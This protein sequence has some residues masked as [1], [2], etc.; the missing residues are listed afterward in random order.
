MFA[1]RF[2]F[3]CV[4]ILVAVCLAGCGGSSSKPVSVTLSQ[5]TAT[6]DPT[7]TLTLTATVANDKNNDGVTWTQ[8]GGGTLT[9]TTSSATYT[10]PAATSSVQTVTITATSVADTS[11]SASATLTIPAKLTITTTGGASG[12]MAGQVGTAYSVQLETTA[13]IPPYTWTLASGN[14]LPAC[15]SMTSSGLITSNGPLTANCAV[16]PNL[17]FDVTDSGNPPMTASQSLDL[18]IAAAPAIVFST[19]TVPPATGTYNSTYTGS[20]LASGG[21]GGLTY[22]LASGSGPLPTGL[23]LG[24]NGA[25][26]GTLTA[27]G[28][29]PFIIQ[30]ADAFGDVQP[31]AYTITVNPETPTLS[32]AAIETQTYGNAPFQVTATDAA[33]TPSTGAITYSL[34]PGQSSV[35]TV[36]SSGMVTLTGAGTVYL[37]ASQAASGNYAAATAT[38]SFTVNGEVPTLTFATISA[39]TYG[40][41]PFTISASD[42]SSTQS[43]GAITYALT[44]GHISAGTVSS[45]G[46]VTITGVGTIYLTASQAANGNFVATS[47]N[48]TITVAPEAATVTLGSLAQTYTGSPLAATATTTPSGIAVSFNYIGTNGTTYGPSATAPT[49][50]GSYSVA[51]TISDPDYTGSA[52]GT[53][54]IAPATATVTIGTQ[55][56]TYTGSPI[57]ATATTTPTGISV[58]FTYTGTGT[59]TYGPSAT[60]PTNAGSYSVAGTI[61]NPNYTGTGSGTLTI[62]QATATVTLGSLSQTYIGSPLAA[63]ATTTPTGL[64]VTF[65]Y[66]GTGTTSYP[67]TSTPPTNAGTYSV[68]GTVS[69]ANYI[70]SGSGTLTIQQATATFMLGNLSQTYTGS[71]LAASVTTTPSDLAV[72]FM[73]TGTGTTNYPATSTPPT[74]AGTYSVTVVVNSAAGGLS[75]NYTGSLSE[76][77]TIAPEPVTLTFTSSTI[78]AYRTY[79]NPAFTVVASDA[80]GP[81]SSG[82]ITYSVTSGPATIGSTTGLVTLTNPGSAAETVYLQAS[83]ASSGNYAS[84][85]VTAS[86]TVYPMLTLPVTTLPTGAVGTS[87]NRNLNLLASGGNGVYSWAVAPSGVTNLAAA[88]LSMF[89]GAAASG[90]GVVSGTLPIATTGPESFSVTVSDTAGNSLTVLM[91][92]TINAALTVSTTTLP[93]GISGSGTSYSQTLAAVGGT[94]TYSSWAVTTG[95]TQLAALGLSLNTS[96]GVISNGTSTLNPGSANFTITVKD[97]SGATATSSQLTINIYAPLTLPAA[98]VTV[99]GPA[100]FG[101][102][103]GEAINV[104]G[105][106]GNY[107]WN[108]TN[109][110][111]AA[112]GLTYTTTGGSPAGSQMYIGGTAPSTA[113][114]INFTVQVT[115]NLT[116][117]STSAIQYSIVVGPTTPLTLQPASGTVL[118]G[119]ITGENYNNQSISL[120]NGTYSGYAFSVGING[121]AVTAGTSWTLPDN[122]TASSSGNTLTISGTPNGTTAITLVVKGTDS[123]QDIAGP[124]TYTLTPT[125]PA[126]LGLPAAGALTAATIGQSYSNAINVTGGDQATYTWTVNSTTLTSGT[127]FAIGATGISAESYGGS[128]LSISGPCATYGTAT[129]DVAVSDIGTGQAIS[130]PVQYTI[131][132][133]P[134]QP[135]ALSPSSNPLPSGTY[136]PSGVSSYPANVYLWASG[137]SNSGY[138]YSVTV[139]GTTTGVTVGNT[140][141][142]GDGL[143]VSTPLAGANILN[144][145]GT[146]T[147]AGD[148]PL[149][150]TLN[151]SANDPVATASY[152]ISI[153]N[154]AAGY[155]VSGNITY[156]GSHTGWTY[157]E[158]INEGGGT[159]GLGTV[160]SE[161]QL[162]AGGAYTIHGVTPGTYQVYAFMDT[163]NNGSQNAVDPSGYSGATVTVSTGNVSGANDTLID[164]TGLNLTSSPTWDTS[165]GWGAFSGGALVDFDIIKNNG[166]ELAAGYTVQWSA[167]SNFSSV[168][169]SQC[170]AATG[171]TT[172]WIVTGIS[173]SGPYYFR[174][175]GI[176]GSCATPTSTGPWSAPSPALTIAAPAGNPVSGTVTIPS[177][178]TLTG[179]PLYVGFYNT[180]TSQIYAT[181]ISNPSNSTP[182]AYS[183]NVPTGSSYFFFAT[184]DQNKTGIMN[185]PGQISNTNSLSGMTLIPITG[186]TTGLDLDLTPYAVSAQAILRMQNTQSTDLSGVTTNSY[187]LRFDV[188][189]FAKLPVSVELATESTPGVIVPT[190]IATG[191]FNGYSDEFDYWPG[192]NGDIP[193]QGDTYKLN[194]I[195]SDGSSNSTTNTPANPLIVTV[196]PI[197]NAFATNLAPATTGVSL[198]PGFTWSYPS[199]ASSSDLYSFSLSDSNGDTIWEIPA[200]HSSSSGFP[201]TITPDITWAVDPTGSGDVPSDPLLNSDST[202]WW[203]ISTSDANGDEAT[204]QVAF[205]TLGTALSLPTTNPSTLPATAILN[206][207]YYGSISVIGGVAPYYWN[208]NFTS[209]NDNLNW[210]TGPDGSSL[211]ISGT[212]NQ[213][214]T[215][216]FQAYVSDSTG[217]SSGWQTYTIT[218]NPYTT[219]D[220]PVSGSISFNG[221]GSSEPPVT[222]T[223]SGNGITQTA[224]SDSKGMYQ[225]PSVPN[226]SYTIT[227]S[228]TGPATSIFTPTSLPVTVNGSFVNN[229]NINAYVGYTVTGMAGY[230]GAQTGPI[231]LSMSGC[232]SNPAPGTAITAPGAFTIHGVPPGVYTLQAWMDGLKKGVPNLSDPVGNTYNVLVPNANNANVSVSLTDQGTPVLSKASFLF[233]A[234]G[235]ANG[236]VLNI[237]PDYEQNSLGN[238]AE[239]ATSYSVQWSTTQ[240]FTSIAGSTSFPAAGGD[241]GYWVLNTASISGLTQG[242]TY[243][244]RTQGVAGTATSNW[245]N[246]V[247]PVTISA[248]PTANTVSGQITFNQTATGPLYVGFFNQNTSQV[249]L[250]QVGTAAAPP[251]SPASYSLQVPSGNN[252]YFFAVLDQNT[253]GIFDAGDISNLDS[254]NV[255]TPAVSISGPATENLTLPS[256]HSSAMVRTQNIY[257]STEWGVGQSYNL[258]YDVTPVGELPIAVELTSAPAGSTIVTPADIAWCFACSMDMNSA[259]SFSYSMG[260]TAPTV[261]AGY[262]LKVSYPD[263]TSDTPTPQVTAVVPNLATNLSPAGPQSSTNNSPDFTWGYPANASSYL[264]QFW[265][266]DSNWNTVWSI[267]IGYAGSNDFTSALTPSLTLSGGDPTNPINTPT[268][269][270]LN[271][272]SLYYWEIQA[273]DA[274]GNFSTYL[275]DLV[276][277]FTPL[278][279]PNPN[280]S[281]LG[282]AYLNQTYTGAITATGGYGGYLYSVNGNSCYGCSYFDLGS[283]LY[284]SNYNGVLTISGVPSATGSV[285][286]TVYAVDTSWQTYV[287]P[288]TYTINIGEAPVTLSGSTSQTVLV[289]SPFSEN[290]NVSG[291][292][293]NSYAFTVSVDGGAATSVPVSPSVLPLA[294]GLSATFDGINQLTISGTPGTAA[295]VSL[296]IYAQDNQGNHA[297][298]NYTITVVAGPNGANNQYLSGT[299]VCKVDGFFDSDGSR[300]TSLV[301]FMAGGAGTFS[302]GAW[303][304]NSRDMGPMSGTAVGSYNIGS[305]NNGLLTMNS[306][307]TTGGSGTNTSQYAIALNNTGSATTATEFRMVEIDDTGSNSSGMTGT[308][309]CYQ[310]T[311]TGVFGTDIFA[312]NS[313]VFRINGEDGSGNPEAILGRF[314][315]TSPTAAGSLTGGVADQVDIIDS[316]VTNMVFTGGSYSAPSAT[317]GRSTLTF[318]V[319]GGAANFEA[320]VIDANRMMVIETDDAKAQS[321]DIRKQLNIST[322]TAANVT[323]PYV[324]YAQG[325]EY[326]DGSLSGYDSG[327]QQMT[328]N[329]AGVLTINQGYADEGGTYQVGK[330]NGGTITV[331]F[332][333]N[334]PGR[335][336]LTGGFPDTM[337]AYMYNTGSGFFMDFDTKVK[338]GNTQNY[339]Q[340]A[341]MEPQSEATFTYAAVAGDYLMGQLPLTEPGTNGNVG[342]VV[343]SGCASSASSCG[344]TGDVTTA[345]EGDFTWDQSIGSMTYDWDTSVTGTG[346][347]LVGSGSNGLSC[348]V[349]SATRDAC[350][351]NADNKP[352]V[353]ILQQ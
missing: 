132:C 170:F 103:Y 30:A 51:G 217:A 105:G 234:N 188:L 68:I 263:G 295:T 265:M 114:T 31:Q 177:T 146:P 338:S 298:Q 268:I 17:T 342:E 289:S 290:I 238:Y 163:L 270:T 321:G 29:F 97:S 293:G 218:V 353:M 33:S 246:V 284:A 1:K 71:P 173:G 253:D 45:S 70:G 196:S 316:S 288:V 205:Q 223:L 99:P 249:Y 225:F 107:S 208:V 157:I 168:A 27:A 147:Q 127:P 202:Y 214:G 204:T 346:S 46:Q 328:G 329:A 332:D 121:G 324:S 193:A 212:P 83:Q 165:Q 155:T 39:E 79:T 78:P 184:L 252:Y 309:D 306:T 119:P 106:S 159:S 272:G 283:G 189:S 314:Y 261:G 308:G 303:D 34:T 93:Y 152:I 229:S 38:T 11:Q 348:I 220:Y 32:F 260:S 85:S 320:Y 88:G 179:G 63:T 228:I 305:D 317:N 327:I 322:Y 254:W 75:A 65:M 274:H 352:S 285:T 187:G 181:E 185:G 35:A 236:A 109:S 294:D 219:G 180:S 158:L 28:K 330:E 315:N 15:L 275:T 345:G 244:F 82:A 245:S 286:F 190:D 239:A 257:A 276:S 131:A 61:S 125:N 312:G 150:V 280:P 186:T 22:S 76:A 318:T 36:T 100:I 55:T 116:H 176:L 331:N 334:N 183:V 256:G 40:N 133:N 137:G 243:Y 344:F 160:I 101:V 19:T 341:W 237:T 49:N 266:G 235:F 292:S 195:Y 8:S 110:G 287:G 240:N 201:S 323:G 53:L 291:G 227:P 124:S 248:P 13:G 242:D 9:S 325:I 172:T 130:T 95:G 44:N 113:Q 148:V 351:F 26:T 72:T 43:S 80:T 12:N 64:A 343:V 142:I 134:Q 18:I 120:T 74:N 89:T 278:A 23:T 54:T 73:Y 301:S 232:V 129:L 340:T 141:P 221:C 277:G 59:T 226:G 118:P 197:L 207:S 267:P 198:M 333:S 251:T 279:L 262:G 200:Q 66:T 16:D 56:Q 67:A 271:T 126:P 94:G 10:A 222:L 296:A 149:N 122:L 140:V 143:T 175:A 169:G 20:V 52:T 269:S 313:F 216:T 87:Y 117:L 145:T 347:Y 162:T 6:L 96:T 154:P 206:Q 123:G 102:G 136:N 47:V 233:L 98:S 230:D 90:G 104:T 92:V 77:M 151:D 194:V 60:A 164:P 282:P 337:I 258:F 255:I 224:V 250:T 108:I 247:G 310:A 156:T 199:G 307:V 161:A 81:V 297:S 241:P 171:S 4:A 300:W 319:S 215:I 115:D 178:V 203:R 210:N 349:I 62:Q 281:S 167:N 182:N 58:S 42:S 339:L 112:A 138:S 5:S 299:Y 304:M 231:Y 191:A 57:P 213:T 21:A 209:G 128:T 84:A 335:A 144:I 14:T 350:I 25:I 50:A 192:L 273:Y 326:V 139:N 86:F 37:T 7:N 111:L 336:T 311:T 174:A 153:I 2:V 3:F 41:A 48:T 166:V 91:Q 24:S 135:L 264:Y 259:F 69:N 302:N 211:I